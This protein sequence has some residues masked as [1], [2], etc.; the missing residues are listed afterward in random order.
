MLR[1]ICRFEQGKTMRMIVSN[2][3]PVLPQNNIVYNLNKKIL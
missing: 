2:T 3:I 1:I